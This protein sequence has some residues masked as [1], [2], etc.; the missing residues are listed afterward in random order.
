MT[1]KFKQGFFTSLSER[2]VL[3][4]YLKEG[5]TS[6]VLDSNVPD[7]VLPY[8]LLNKD[9]IRVDLSLKFE[10]PTYLYENCVVTTLSFNK[11]PYKVRIPYTAIYVVFHPYDED[12]PLVFE[13]NIPTSQRDQFLIDDND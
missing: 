2:E 8:Q 1:S 5:K 10:H 6:L 13:K 12:H 11:T 3:L 9:F 7:T 4:D